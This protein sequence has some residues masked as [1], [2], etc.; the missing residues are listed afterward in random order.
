MSLLT[1]A[2]AVPRPRT[3]NLI[4][5]FRVVL[6]IARIAMW[7]VFKGVSTG[8][9]TH[10]V[11]TVYGGVGDNGVRREVLGETER[12]L[13]VLQDISGIPVRYRGYSIQLLTHKKRSPTVVSEAPAGGPM[14]D[15]SGGCSR[16]GRV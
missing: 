11:P 10:G 2:P 13:G 15:G 6:C 7:D 14:Q 3:S 5:R 12:Y 9:L 16:R 1:P 8:G 4:R